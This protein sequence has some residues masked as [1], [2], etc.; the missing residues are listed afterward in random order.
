[1]ADTVVL[2]EVLS[3]TGLGVARGFG[4][5]VGRG[6][7]DADGVGVGS[8]GEAVG[9]GVGEGS[10]VGVGLVRGAVVPATDVKI[11]GG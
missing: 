9:S 3:A 4:D 5:R 10:T 2:W 6:F 11:S 7:G 8:D 1:V